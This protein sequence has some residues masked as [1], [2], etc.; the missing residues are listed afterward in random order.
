MPVSAAPTYSIVRVDAH[1]FTIQPSATMMPPTATTSFGPMRSASQPSTG[2]N[3]VS[4][5][6]KMLN[7]T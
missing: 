5:A 7:A 1:E 2:V 4:S 3:Q 6:T